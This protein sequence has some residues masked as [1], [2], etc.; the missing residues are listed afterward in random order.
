[1]KKKP[2]FFESNFEITAHDADV[3]EEQELLLLLSSLMLV[4]L[5]RNRG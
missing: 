4:Q 5:E 3:S 2:S 1:M